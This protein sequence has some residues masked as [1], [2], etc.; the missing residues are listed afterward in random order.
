MSTHLRDDTLTFIFTE[1]TALTHDLKTYDDSLDPYDHVDIPVIQGPVLLVGGFPRI[2]I[3][4]AVALLPPRQMVDRMIARF[5]EAKES[6]WA[7][8]HIPTF[9]KQYEAFWDNPL[10]TT[11]TWIALLFVLYSHAALYFS[12]S[13]QELPGGMGSAEHALNESKY[14]A[15]QCLTLADYTMPGPY[16]VETIILYFGVEY[17]GRHQFI[18]G[19]STLLALT[20]RL[21]MHMGMHRDP[22]HYPNMAPFEGEMRR[23]LWTILVEIDLLVSFQFGVPSNIH[24]SNYD[25]EPPRNLLDEDF[26]QDTKELPP[27]RPETESTVSLMPIVR[28]RLVEAFRA[29]V[30][31]TAA[32]NPTSYAEIMRI[33]KLVEDA[34]SKIPPNLRYRPFSQS[35]FDPPLLLMQRQWLEMLCT[36]H[37][38]RNPFDAW[39]VII[40]TSRKYE[41]GPH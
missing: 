39:T 36:S 20:T 21:A 30:T 12:L 41:R 1:I 38:P 25:T 35:L 40:L 26:D 17:L 18:L 10:D 9:M 27:S 24:K 3:A 15:A 7:I 6:A 22:K 34:H 4:E 33:D 2:S 16:K 5:F 8:F 11:Y 29:V 31:A 14:R 37:V 23:R 28:N 19:T 13:G 32:G